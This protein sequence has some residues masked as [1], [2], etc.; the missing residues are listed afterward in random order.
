MPEDK[1]DNDGDNDINGIVMRLSVRLTR[2]INW[3]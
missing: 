2:T 3:K 1:E